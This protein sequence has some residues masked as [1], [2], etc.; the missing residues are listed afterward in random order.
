M[1]VAID[2]TN[3]TPFT[4]LLERAELPAT[5]PPWLCPNVINSL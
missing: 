4:A 1:E 3:M 5:T 2:A